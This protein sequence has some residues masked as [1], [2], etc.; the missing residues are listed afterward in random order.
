MIFTPVRKE[1]I[2]RIDFEKDRKRMYILLSSL[3]SQPIISLEEPDDCTHFHIAIHGLSEDD[4]RRV[5]E[6]KG[7]GWLNNSQGAWIRITSLRQLAQGRVQPDWLERFE[8]MLSYAERKG[9]LSDNR[10]AVSGHCEWD[11]E[12]PPAFEKEKR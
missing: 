2:A 1:L 8:G 6:S 3:K 7:V 4:A 5:L 12:M 9:W 10:E 11:L